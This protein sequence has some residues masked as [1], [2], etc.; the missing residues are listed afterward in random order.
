MIKRTQSAASKPRKY[1][2]K[3]IARQIRRKQ[4]KY[5]RSCK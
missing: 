2:P 4:R 3:K 1:K 5:D